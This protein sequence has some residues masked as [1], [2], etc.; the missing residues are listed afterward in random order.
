MES[1]DS[2]NGNGRGRTPSSHLDGGGIDP[3]LGA[4]DGV[5]KDERLPKP[6][7]NGRTARSRGR[8]PDPDVKAAP[9]VTDR[10]E[11]NARRKVVAHPYDPATEEGCPLLWDF[12]IRQENSKGQDRLLPEIVLKRADGGWLVVIRDCDTCQQ[13]VCFAETFLE[14]SAAI[15]RHFGSGRDVWTAYKNY[16]NPDGIDRKRKKKD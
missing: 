11:G 8:A 12:I 5:P 2:G 16:A 13:T 4:G 15:E 14:L 10:L 3:V 6:L 7:P 1:I 9:R